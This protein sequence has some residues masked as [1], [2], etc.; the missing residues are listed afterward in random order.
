[1]KLIIGLG[2]P[3][4]KYDDTRHNI[5][6]AFLECL[7][8]KH[9]IKINKSECK[10]LTGVG[11]I[12]GEQVVLAK[13]QTFMN[14]SGESVKSLVAKY[15][16]KID[17]VLV[18]FDDISLDVGRMRVRAKGSAGGHNGIKS[19]IYQL[20]SEDF[21]RLKIGVGGKPFEGMDLA[22][23][24]LGRF[25]KDDMKIMTDM[26]PDVCDCI[27]LMLEGNMQQAMNRYNQ[28]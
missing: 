23:H 9:N 10:A 5:G 28:R 13:P 3:G 6:F 21:P 15:K 7:A 14:L 19:I 1:M 2:N 27:E 12:A 17:D 8:H 24:V 18:V 16:C 22:D 20:Q 11:R 25:S 26:I 4:K